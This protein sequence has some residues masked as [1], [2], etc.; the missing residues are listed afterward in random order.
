M[1]NMYIARES[2]TQMKIKLSTTMQYKKIKKI[3]KNEQR[4]KQKT[5]NRNVCNK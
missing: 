3:K 1:N 2:F 5:M 4:E